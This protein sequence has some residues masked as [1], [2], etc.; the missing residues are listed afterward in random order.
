MRSKALVPL[1]VALAVHLATAAAIEAEPPVALRAVGPSEVG[2]AVS[3]AVFEGDLRR[4]PAPAGWTPGTPA[5]ETGEHHELGKLEPSSDPAVAGAEAGPDPLVVQQQSRVPDASGGPL[6]GSMPGFDGIPFAGTNPPDTVGAVGPDHFI[7]MVNSA[8]ASTGSFGSTFAVYDKSGTLVAGP[9]ALE[10]LWP[11]GVCR[12]DTRGDPIVLYD[13]LANRWLMSQLTNPFPCLFTAIPCRL[14]VAVSRTP[15]PISGG[16]Y[17][18]DFPASTFPDYPK[19]A[20]NLESYLVSSNSVSV[21]PVFEQ[22]VGVYA[23]DRRRMLGGQPAAI[24]EFSAPF[25][26]NAGF[27]QSLVPAD[28]DGHRL[29][30]PGSPGYFL[31][32]RDGEVSDGV[33]DLDRDHLE[34]WELSVSWAHSEESVLSGPTLVEI[35]EFGSFN[36]SIPQPET[37]DGLA[38]FADPLMWRV[39]YRNFGAHEALVGNF[40]VDADG[41]DHAG[42]RWFELRRSGDGSWSRH[43]EGTF[44]PDAAHRWMASVAM[45]RDGNLALGYSVSSP[46]LDV[47]PSI[48]VT[49]RQAG[50]PPGTLSPNELTLAEGDAASTTGLWG[51][52]SAMTVDPRDDCTFWYTNEYVRADQA[53]W[54]TR[55]GSFRFPGCHP[56]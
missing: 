37:Q 22:K 24:Q 51:D 56:R 29:P 33:V 18:Y 12:T 27:I 23:L 10:E 19:Y 40:T 43:Q 42:V 55:I 53:G 47:F 16:W 44:A 11:D 4:L 3:P 50:D 48:R 52:Y 26:P 9:A 30:P 14:C 20:V 1:V 5:S 34:L 46:E 28:L 15:D 45:D 35:A 49:G 17:L 39:S 2:A 41:T 25:L 13:H 38:P 7:Q 6:A 54:S 8:N 21:F 31:R 32:Y 36:A